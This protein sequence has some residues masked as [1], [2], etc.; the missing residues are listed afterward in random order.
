MRHIFL[1]A[2]ALIVSPV[3]VAQDSVEKKISKEKA[4][5]I[6][7]TEH[8]NLSY[9]KHKRH[10]LDVY[11]PEKA[12][13]SPII[14]IVH[15]GG[16]RIGDKASPNLIENKL[17]K[18]GQAGFILVSS[19]YRLLPTLPYNQAHD[20]RHALKYVQNNASK[21][22]GDPNKI[23]LMGHSAGA[24][25]VALV[26][27]NPDIAY[28]LG[29]KPWLG[30]VFLDS[31]VFDVVDLMQKPHLPLYDKAFGSILYTWR[32][33]S[34]YH[35]LTEKAAPMLIVCSTKRE[36]A[37]PQGEH[38]LHKAESL[39]VK[40]SILPQELSHKNINKYLGLENEYTVFVE[41]FI[42]TLLGRSVINY[43]DRKEDD[44]AERR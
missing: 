13:N 37:C 35:Q 11:V 28:K 17:K 19:N 8:M 31:A 38:F 14:F 26:N 34:P 23:I 29:V 36:Y 12:K 40:T 20:L 16:W 10:H 27:A 33:S 41:E 44:P 42:N 4:P 39:K 24:H 25:L 7:I 21:W 3:A 22:G 1:I 43:S 32:K 15:G 18:W 5:L 2:F 9:G 30:A 6:K